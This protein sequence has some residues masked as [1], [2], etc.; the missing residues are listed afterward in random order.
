MNIWFINHYAV[1]T[2]LYP[3]ARPASLAKYLIKAGHKVTIFAASTVH[4]SD[5]NLITNN[6]KFR[7]EAENGI[8]Y[9]YIRTTDYHGNG[10]KR[11]LNMLQYAVRLP[12]VCKHFPKPDAIIATSATPIACTAGLKLAKKY[13]CIGIAEIADLWPETFVAYGLIKEGSPILVPMYWYEKRMYKM[14]GRIIFTMEGGRDYIIEK[15]WDTEHGGPV[16]I[17]KVFHINNGVDIEEFEFNRA[18]YKVSDPDLDD[19]RTFKVVYVG[20]IRMVNN[21]KRIVDTAAYIN[22]NHASNIRFLIYGDGTDRNDLE[23][24]CEEN[25]INNI[26]FKGFVEKKYIP[27]ILSKS[28]LNI[29]HFEQNRIKKYGLSLNKMFEYFAS[30]KPTVSDCESGYDL[31]KRYNCGT[32]ID[33]ADPEQMAEEIINFSKK[34]D[35][36]YNEYCINA[37][38]ASRDFDFARLADKLLEIMDGI[39]CYEK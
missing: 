12:S 37:I 31:I 3:L 1:P 5:L 22:K 29:I 6:N 30:G 10:W 2:H 35:E 36:Q 7:V 21:V 38:K 13:K 27:Y 23:R 16:D 4:N 26:L 28:D 18:N 25:G 17:K 33:N 24:Y 14:A 8:E 32:V 20:A 9:V 39:C 34:T 15:G 11:I 19:W